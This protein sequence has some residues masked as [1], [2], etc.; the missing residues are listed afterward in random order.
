M[1]FGLVLFVT[2]RVETFSIWVLHHIQFQQ[3]MI[4]IYV[5]TYIFVVE[6]WMC[7]DMRCFFA[8]KIFKYQQHTRVYT[9][10]YL[11]MGV[12]KNRGV[13]PQ[14]IHV[15][16]VFHEINHPFWGPTPIFGNT[17]IDITNQ[18]VSNTC[19]LGNFKDRSSMWRLLGF[20]YP[21]KRKD[22]TPWN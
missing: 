20:F 22:Y 17:H 11:Y 16:R 19:I 7:K 12:S 21:W 1:F 15:N 2:N 5:H 3:Y 9:H 6:L 18:K 8:H 14:I 10:M 4:Y 13:S